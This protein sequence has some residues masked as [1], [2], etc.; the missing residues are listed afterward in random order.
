MMAL[1]IHTGQDTDLNNYIDKQVEF[2]QQPC[3]II[4]NLCGEAGQG[5]AAQRWP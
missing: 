2:S 1:N 3:Q 5:A 4:G